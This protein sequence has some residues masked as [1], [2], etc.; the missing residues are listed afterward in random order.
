MSK[1]VCLDWKVF[2]VIPANAGIHDRRTYAERRGSRVLA[3]D[4]KNDKVRINNFLVCFQ[5][6]DIVRYQKTGVR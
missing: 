6:Q 3:R 2:F 1:I 5:T 4:D